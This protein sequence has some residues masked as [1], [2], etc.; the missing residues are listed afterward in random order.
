[1]SASPEKKAQRDEQRRQEEAKDRRSILLYTVIGVAVAVA[2]VALMIWRSGLLQRSVTALNVG[3]TKY[4]AVEFQYYYNTIYSNHANR[5]DFVPSLPLKE[6]T[7]DQESGQNW[8]DRLKE[9]TIEA[10]AADTALA[11]RAKS[12]GYTLSEEAQQSLDASISQLDT[13]WINYA[14]SRD[15]FIRASFGPYMTYDKLVSLLELDFLS[16][17]YASTQLE[18]IEHPDS[19]YE[20]YYQDNTDT[21]DTI[22]YTQLSFRA[23]AP[24]TD[25][26]GNP[27]ELTAEE[28]AAALEKEKAEKKALAEEVKSR[29]DAGED[30]EALAEEYASQLHST[31]LSRKTSAYNASFSTYSSWLLDSSR[32][33]GDVTLA[34]QES[35]DAYYYYVSVF[36]DRFRDEE[37]THSVRHL[38][39]PAGSG[40]GTQTPTQEE[41]DAAEEQAQALLDEWKAGEASEDTFSALAAANSSDTSSAA[42]GGLI[43]GISSNS[44]YVEPFLNWS[45]DPARKPGDTELVKTEYGWHIMYYVSTDDPVWRLTAHSALQQEDY[46]E[47]TAEATQDMNISQGL[48][49]NFISTQ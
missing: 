25:S 35:S 2:A 18:K 4:T 16:S 40:T 1:M 32:R 41:Y 44:S 47:L 43:S 33:A 42:N 24:S 17:D 48:G 6:Q 34:E 37:N 10:L 13:L 12:E 27:T 5:Y 49:M 8:Q 14:V 31:S 38:L 23:A 11:A 30:P 26:Q 20:T 22:V 45:I 36:E 19:D 7:Y 46:E 15:D 21:L 3:G 9:E 29:L 39:I 28:K